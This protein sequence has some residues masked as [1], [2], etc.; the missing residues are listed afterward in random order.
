[1]IDLRVASINISGIRSIER[2]RLLLQ[3]CLE[4]NLDLV[5]LQEVTFH[6]CSVLGG[7]Y[8]VLSNVGPRRRGTAVLIR[9]GIH[10]SRE[11]LDPDGRLISIDVGSFTFIN[12]YAPSGLIAREERNIFLRQTIPAYAVSTNLPLL[13]VGDFNCVNEA[14]DRSTPNPR[15]SPSRIT[16]LA[17]REMISGLELVDIWKKLKPG[18]PGHTFHHSNGSCRIDRVFSSRNNSEHVRNIQLKP[19]SISDHLS[20]E[21]TILHS[22]TIPRS[23][24]KNKN[25]WKLNTAVL[26]EDEFKIR[27]TSFIESSLNHPLRENDCVKWWENIFK[28]G[29]KRVAISY[30]KERANLIRNTKLF[31]QTCILDIVNTEPLDWIAFKEL[32]S[33]SKSW[34]ESLLQGFG[35]RSHSFEG[36]DVEKA[37]VFHVKKTRENF[38]NCSIDTL[39]SPSG[40]EISLKD[41]VNRTIVEHF[42]KIFKNRASS[43]NTFEAAFLDGVRDRCR[44]VDF[45]VAPINPIEIKLALLAT[46]RNKSPGMDGIPIEFYICFW[47][48]IAPH[49]LDMFI[50]VLERDSIYLSQGRAAI[51]LIP[52]SNGSCGVSGFRPISLLNTDY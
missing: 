14:L 7:H 5:A 43:D 48:L 12:I 13:L 23:R 22:G 40:E 6:E 25:L 31:Y 2:R 47:D 32:R 4:G 35:V 41:E 34:E 21:C 9:K 51:R 50:H 18:E 33:Y 20:L 30:C 44:N 42:E 39:I 16:N 37:T 1:M 24:F 29:V 46:K 45:L 15:P 17:L 3:F 36:P 52:K 38:R 27:I 49:F 10:F 26:S 28:P 8:N 19:L 11:L